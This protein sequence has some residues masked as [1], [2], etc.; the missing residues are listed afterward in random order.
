MPFFSFKID[1]LV[2]LAMS[3][4][5]PFSISVPLRLRAF[6]LNSLSFTALGPSKSDRLRS[7]NMYAASQYSDRT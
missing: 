6:S 2:K 7:T 4:S 3:D 5:A 1:L